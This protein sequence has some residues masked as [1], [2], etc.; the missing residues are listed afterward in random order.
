[1][2][3]LKRIISIGTFNSIKCAYVIHTD[4]NTKWYLGTELHRIDGPAIE[5][6]NGDKG[7]Y[8][9]NKRHR[10]DGPAVEYTNGDKAWYFYNK[11]HHINGPTINYND[12]YKAWYFNDIKRKKKNTIL[13]CIIII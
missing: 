12:G 9:N 2:D 10:I 5:H 7:W 13:L 6:A 1:M 8:L 11:L 3:C 4:T